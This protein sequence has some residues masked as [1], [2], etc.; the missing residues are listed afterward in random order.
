MEH[1]IVTG[2][3]LKE[4][5]FAGAA[6]SELPSGGIKVEAISGTC[7]KKQGRWFFMVTSIGDESFEPPREFVTEQ[8]T[9]S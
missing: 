6:W 2:I 1:F 4:G 3:E 8:V 9:S 5:S 7:T